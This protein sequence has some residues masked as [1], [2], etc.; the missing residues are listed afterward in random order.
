MKRRQ[1]KRQSIIPGYLTISGFC[2]YLGHAVSERTVR[3][4]LKHPTHPLPCF[5]I[6]AKTVIISRED[7]DNW[8][9][10]F[11]EGNENKVDDLV[12]EVMKNLT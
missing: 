5:R 4:W 11:A 1:R 12:N 8:I 6:S 3:E 2:E 9:Q 7:A 10:Q